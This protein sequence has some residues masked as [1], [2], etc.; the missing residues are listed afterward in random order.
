[1]P[2][3][4]TR[5]AVLD[6]VFRTVVETGVAVGAMAVPFRTAV[7]QGDVLQRADTHAFTA[8]N[9]VVGA[10]ER[11]VGNPLVEAF[12]DD[13]G[14]ETR[15]DATSH[16]CHGFPLGDGCDDLRQVCFGLLDFTFC[17]F[18]LVGAHARHV[19]VGV[20]HLEAEVSVQ[21]QPDFRQLL[22]ENLFRHSAVVAA[23]DRYPHVGGRLREF[24]FLYKFQYEM[25]RLPRINR[26]DETHPFAF[27]K[28]VFESARLRE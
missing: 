26:E 1:M 28:G 20:W 6:G 5:L 2:L 4:D 16:L 19:D 18:W 17:Y 3:P 27:G 13:V 24:Q 7:L 25:R 11:L 22:S 10:A 9:A 14:L 23:G 8:R 21:C 12:P 15:E